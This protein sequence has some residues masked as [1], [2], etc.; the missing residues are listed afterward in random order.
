MM[1]VALVQL[2]MHACLPAVAPGCQARGLRAEGGVRALAPP[3]E[4]VQERAPHQ[5]SFR[6][7]T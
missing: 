2:P 5:N 3:G 7:L 1:R 6:L 4:T